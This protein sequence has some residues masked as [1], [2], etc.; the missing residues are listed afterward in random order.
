MIILA[1]LGV[2]LLGAVFR[3]FFMRSAEDEKYL[4]NFAEAQKQMATQ[5]QQRDTDGAQAPV[6]GPAAPAKSR[7]KKADVDIDTLASSIQQV[8]FDY[9][10]VRTPVNP[11]TPLVGPMAPMRL[12][13]AAGTQ[14]GQ[15]ARDR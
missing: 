13:A 7:F 8:D 6:G 2:V 1:V 5:A 3:T 10:A 9:D 11:M 4:A 12:A 15:P 14:K